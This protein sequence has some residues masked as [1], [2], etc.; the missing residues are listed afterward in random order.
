MIHRT[1]REGRVLSFIDA[2]ISKDYK[3]R[4]RAIFHRYWRFTGPQGKGEGCVS[5][6]LTI[7]RTTREGR[8][9]SFM[10]TDD[11]QDQK[12]RESVVF[13]GH[14]RFTGPQGKGEGHLSWTLTI[15]RTRRE[16]RGSSFMDTDDSKNHKEMERTVFHGYWRFTGPQGK[17]E[18]HFSWIL[19]IHRTTRKWRGMFFMDTDN[20]EEQKGREKVIFHGYWRFTEPQGN[21]EGCLSWILTLYRSTR[22]ME[23]AIIFL[24]Y[25]FH[26]PINIQTYSTFMNI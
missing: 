25:Y 21:G 12:G 6:I 11:S 15:H 24:H 23:R 22:E 5:W 13:H 19:T 14:W 2:D 8:G 17:G 7:N 16:G 9:L 3:E 4:Q 1:A 20:L 18:G 26:L 10:D